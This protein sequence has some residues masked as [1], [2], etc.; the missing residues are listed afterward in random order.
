MTRA[1]RTRGRR[2]SGGVAATTAF[3]PSSLSPSGWWRISSTEYNGVPWTGDV[4]GNLVT[5]GSDPAVGAAL[6]GFDTPDF[7]GSANIISFPSAASNFIGAAG[8]G[9]VLFNADTADAVDDALIIE[10]AFLCI[11]GALDFLLNFST[12]GVRLGI[13]DGTFDSVKVA[14][15]TGGWHCAQWR[16]SGGTA[17]LRVDGGAFSTFASAAPTSLAGTLLVGQ[18]YNG[19][20]GKTFDGRIAELFIRSATTS[21]ADFDSCRTYLNSRY[22]VS[23]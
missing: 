8:S 21:D 13:H 2:W 15:A 11:L 3:S 19:T 4:G 16:Y 1:L 6:N 9:Y 14:C 22:G 17:G 7:D 20:A 18:N 10:P 5:T 23:V 12:A